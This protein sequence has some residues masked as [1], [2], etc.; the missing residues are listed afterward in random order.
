VED[1]L[2]GQAAVT[3]LALVFYELCT[4]SVKYGALSREAGL[5]AVSSERRGDR[6][7]IH[8]EETL[9]PMQAR[10]AVP[11]QGFGTVMCELALQDQLDG[12]FSRQFTNSG[13]RARLDLSYARLAGDL[14]DSDS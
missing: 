12:S 14:Y 6:L 4:N 13:M 11:G 8:W 3:P 7:I 2:V 1:V 5:L 10:P 9:S